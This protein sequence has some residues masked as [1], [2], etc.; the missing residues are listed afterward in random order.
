M[1]DAIIVGARVAGAPTAM[2]LARK[3]YKVLLV[4]KA[5]FPSDTLS[6][7]QLQIPG[8]VLLKQ[9]GLLDQ[10]L[11]TNPGPARGAAFD[12]GYASFDGNYPALDGVNHI[13]SP[14]RYL[15]DAILV[16]AAGAAGAEV[17]QGFATQE[18]IFDNERVIGI[19]GQDR[20]GKSYSDYARIV[21]G[22]D[23][24]HS[25]VAK[26][27][28][29]PKYHE[30]PTQT[31][32]YYSYFSDLPLKNGKGEMY[33]R[34]R[35]LFGCW[36]TNDNLTMIYTARPIAEFKE[37]K[38]NVEGNYMAT[39]DAVPEFAERVRAAKRVEPIRGA[40]DLPNYFRK[41]YGEGW[42]LIGDAGFFKDPINGHG[43]ND[44]FRDAALVANAVDDGFSGRVPIHQALAA[45]QQERDSKSKPL[46]DFTLELASMKPP[47]PEQIM[48]FQALGRSQAAADN[49]LGVMA[50]IVPIKEFLSLKNVLGLIGVKGM[51]QALWQKVFPPRAVQP[52]A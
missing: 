17:R 2:L 20:D 6:S 33:A 36:P 32:G 30:Q 46:Y 7:H 1:Y 45:Y 12:M 48:M 31:L 4:D 28:N 18:L 27:V 24:R 43:I 3:G 34:G 40:G 50:G 16:E 15:L 29:A 25:I 22:A 35:Q 19:R 26:A 14:R 37:F 21:I 39:F 44:A 10:V 52:A 47:A 11:A 13:I 38:I 8:S 49:F 51:A 41:P 9:W 23:G 42:A 5:T